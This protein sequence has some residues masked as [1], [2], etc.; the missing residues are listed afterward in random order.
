M[1]GGCGYGMLTKVD[2]LIERERCDLFSPCICLIYFDQ[3][4]PFLRKINPWGNASI[5]VLAV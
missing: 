4:A 1:D 2:F 3:S 5:V